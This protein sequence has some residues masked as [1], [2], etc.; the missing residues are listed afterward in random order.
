MENFGLQV[1]ENT[2]RTV[3][4]LRRIE[5]ELFT[6]SGEVKENWGLQIAENTSRSVYRLRRIQ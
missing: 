5:G 6:G 3:D 1:E 2:W 4:M